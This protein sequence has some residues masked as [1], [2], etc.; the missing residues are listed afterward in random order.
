MRRVIDEAH[1]ENATRLL[2]VILGIA[3]GEAVIVNGYYLWQKGVHDDNAILMIFLVIFYI[4][5]ASLP[6]I[7][8][9]SEKCGNQWLRLC[10][11]ACRQDRK[12]A[13]SLPA[14][15]KFRGGKTGMSAREFVA[16]LIWKVGSRI[17]RNYAM[18]YIRSSV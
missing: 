16:A 9:G 5:V 13:Y 1:R 6:A 14:E 17:E 12:Y 15:L 10:F 8:N 11:T 18:P 7:V 3:C 4:V 2:L